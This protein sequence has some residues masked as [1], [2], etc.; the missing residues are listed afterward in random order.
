MLLYLTRLKSTFLAS[1]GFYSYSIYLFH[2][3]FTAGARIVLSRF[4]VTELWVLFTFAL[5]AGLAGPLIVE[6]V[7]ARY[8]PA[9][10]FML[11]KRPIA[12]K[13]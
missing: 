2:V 13:P 6:L 7:A 12:A 3:F 5:A 4:G 11:G 10:I 1:I 8:N 9:R